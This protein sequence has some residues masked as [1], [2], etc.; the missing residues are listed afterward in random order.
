MGGVSVAGVGALGAAGAGWAG[1]GSFSSFS[2]FLLRKKRKGD[3]PRRLALP[4]GSGVVALLRCPLCCCPILVRASSLDAALRRLPEP[5]GTCRVVA[6]SK[7]CVLVSVPAC[8][9]RRRCRGVGGRCSTCS[10]SSP[11]AA[12]SE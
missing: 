4:S 12:S 5:S 6:A 11:S 1:A 2:S 3:L 8:T 9:E 10:I 7:D